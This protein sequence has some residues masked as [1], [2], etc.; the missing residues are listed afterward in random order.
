MKNK[1]NKNNNNKKISA[2][3]PYARFSFFFLKK[4]TN[5]FFFKNLYCTGLVQ[6]QPGKTRGFESWKVELTAGDCI[7]PIAI[8][9]S[10]TS[11]PDSFLI[12]HEN[13]WASA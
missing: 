10:Q 13:E 1:N 6:E 7:H 4:K 2:S 8:S 9:S 11:L 12:H 5:F 3:V